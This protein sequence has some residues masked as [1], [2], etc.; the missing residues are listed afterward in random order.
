MI[1][2]MTEVKILNFLPGIFFGEKCCHFCRFGNSFRT[3]K[4][5]CEVT[6]HFFNGGRRYKLFT[7]KGRM[8]V[9]F[10]S[11]EKQ[12]YCWFFLAAFD[13]TWTRFM[14]RLRKVFSRKI[15]IKTIGNNWKRLCKQ[16]EYLEKKNPE[17]LRTINCRNKMKN[18]R[19]M[20]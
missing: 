2:V 18:L 11:A 1:G 9:F 17:P 13:E 7:C 8:C 16:P 15:D 12:S 20:P 3:L 19:L 5:F 4:E 6:T 14:E 10:Y